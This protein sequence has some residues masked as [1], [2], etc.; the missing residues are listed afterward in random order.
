MQLQKEVIQKQPSCEK[1]CGLENLEDKWWP[2]KGR[3]GNLI[4]N[5]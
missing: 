2:R 1:V 4:A 3:D 5:F